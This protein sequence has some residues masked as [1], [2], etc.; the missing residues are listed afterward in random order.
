M[1]YLTLKKKDDVDKK[2]DNVDAALV[3]KFLQSRPS[4]SSIFRKFQDV[5]EGHMLANA[6]ISPDIDNQKK[7][8]SNVI[9]YFDTPLLIRL[10]GLIGNEEKE[11]I[12]ELVS[13]LKILDSKLYYFEHTIDE[14]KKVIYSSALSIN[15][16]HG[17]GNIIQHARL[18]GM[19][20]ADLLL[21]SARAEDELHEYGF[22][23]RKSPSYDRNKHNYEIDETA[24]RKTL[25]ENIP[26]SNEDAVDHDV[27]SIR[28]IHVIRADSIPYTLEKSKA[29]FVTSN[30]S[31]SKVAYDFG[32][33]YPVSQRV[34]AVIT[35][36]S[37]VNIAWLKAP[38]QAP[39]LPR[40]EIIAHA[41]AALKPSD[42]YW[43]KVLRECE[44]LKNDGKISEDDYNLLKYSQNFQEDFMGCTL[45]SDKAFEDETI[46]EI[47]EKIKRSNQK[48]FD[49]VNENNT[50][51]EKERTILKESIVDG[52][53]KRSNNLGNIIFIFLWILYASIFISILLTIFLKDFIYRHVFLYIL[54]TL[55]QVFSATITFIKYK[56]NINPA[57]V[58]SIVIEWRKKQLIEKKT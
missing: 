48:K 9:F 54:T 2:K 39:D 52:I 47:L 56:Y 26:Y 10:L 55:F 5:V 29:I 31:L 12:I 21:K 13:I 53:N 42:E 17:K 49:Q 46:P 24:L 36:F 35:D 20:K 22:N 43:S 58:K 45:G 14:L 57:T 32:K 30:T 18:S 41:F 15:S 7:K 3:G 25:L 27:R 11:I 37:L 44:K 51:L 4:N 8:F 34:P 6:F 16:P 33:D 23:T 38:T 19:G 1:H 40:K 28:A 50:T